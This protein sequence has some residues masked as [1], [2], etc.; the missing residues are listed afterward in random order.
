MQRKHPETLPPEALRQMGMKELLQREEFLKQRKSTCACLVSMSKTDLTSLPAEIEK[1]EGAHSRFDV[2]R[3]AEKKGK[4]AD[5][6]KE[7]PELLV[8]LQ[9]AE[10]ELAAVHRQLQWRQ[11]E[12]Q[13]AQ[14]GEPTMWLLIL[15]VDRS[16]P[17]CEFEAP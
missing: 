11:A 10:D 12:R 17:C 14:R 16:M 8:R 3:L 7:Y 13:L 4:L 1:L 5:R 9:I 15:N 6:R 2:S